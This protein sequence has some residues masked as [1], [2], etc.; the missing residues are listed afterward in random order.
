VPRGSVAGDSAWDSVA[1]DLVHRDFVTCNSFGRDT[2]HRNF[3][4]CNSVA[5]DSVTWSH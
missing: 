1:R 2:V 5:R 3:I 4:T